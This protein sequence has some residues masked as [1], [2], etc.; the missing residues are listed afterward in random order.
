[1]KVTVKIRR[2]LTGD[3]RAWC[4]ALPGCAVLGKSPDDVKQKMDQAIRGYLASLN[5]PT[6][7]GLEQ[8]VLTG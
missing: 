3:Y 5:V 6:L 1:M 2:Q 7:S 4:P 8:Q